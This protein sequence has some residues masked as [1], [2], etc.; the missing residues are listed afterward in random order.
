MSMHTMTMT[1]WLVVAWN[2]SG[3]KV[4]KML[5]ETKLHLIWFVP[6]CDQSQ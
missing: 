2:V 3:E 1:R 4:A 5:C 6:T